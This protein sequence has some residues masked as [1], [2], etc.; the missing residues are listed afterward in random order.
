M[1]RSEMTTKIVHLIEKASGRGMDIFEKADFILKHI[2]LL[3]MLPPNI[4]AIIEGHLC[5][6]NEWEPEDEL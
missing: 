5:V 6:V 4:D 3:G 1:K 2:E